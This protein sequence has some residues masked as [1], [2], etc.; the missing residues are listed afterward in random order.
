MLRAFL[1]VLFLLPLAA[2]HAQAPIERR[3]PAT[4]TSPDPVDP[5]WDIFMETSADAIHQPIRVHTD[6]FTLH[7]TLTAVTPDGLACHSAV[8]FFL[9]P[10]WDN[11]IPRTHIV[12]VHS[13][14]R[15]TSGLIGTLV[16]FGLGTGIAAAHGQSESVLYG[17]LLGGIAG[18]FSFSVPFIHHVLYRAP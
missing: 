4:T 2:A 12:K 3:P 10:R 5:A 13:P 11:P 1:I 14:D 8:P 16:G 9:L 17:A 15:A 18:S 6:R 7:C